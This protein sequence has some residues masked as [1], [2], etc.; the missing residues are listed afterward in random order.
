MAATITAT[1]D[2]EQRIAD[3]EASLAVALARLEIAVRR[4]RR[5][6]RENQELRLRLREAGLDWR[7]GQ[8][9]EKGKPLSSFSPKKT[10]SLAASSVSG[11]AD[12]D[13]NC[14]AA[15][16]NLP[17]TVISGDGKAPV[18]L[19]ASDDCLEFVELRARITPSE[20]VGI[21]SCS[22]KQKKRLE[23]KG[24]AGNERGW[25]WRLMGPSGKSAH[26][27]PPT[28]TKAL[29]AE[30]CDRSSKVA[31]SLP[32]SLDTNSFSSPR[33]P[34]SKM[35]SLA[36][37]S[38]NGVV[39]AAEWQHQPASLRVPEPVQEF[40]ELEQGAAGAKPGEELPPEDI[41]GA[42]TGE[43]HGSGSS[44][45]Q[46]ADSGSGAWDILWKPGGG[47]KPLRSLTFTA[48]TETR[49]QIHQQVENWADNH[50]GSQKGADELP[51]IPTQLDNPRPLLLFRRSGASVEAAESESPA[52][53]P[54]PE[55]GSSGEVVDPVHL[56]E[57]KWL[58]HVKGT[59]DIL[60]EHHIRCL[61][62]QL[63]KRMHQAPWEL[64]YSTERHGISMQTL[65][66][67]AASSSFTVLV[68]CDGAG[69]VFGSFCTEP[70]K[71]S[72]RY[73]GTGESFVFQ[74]QP[75]QIAY[76]WKRKSKERNDFF[77]FATP[78]SV[79][80]GGGGHFALWLD[81]DLAFGN[82][83]VSDTFGN[84][85]LAGSDEFRI[86]QIELWGIRV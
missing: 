33:R 1:E 74:L 72:P 80:V 45:E 62:N 18:S 43:D 3:L 51:A 49:A 56:V 73:F 21:K 17:V 44:L 26:A 81:Q 69:Y 65:F 24:S 28:S 64:L 32:K 13:G 86:K 50:S 55:A 79:A 14:K 39:S 30:D 47:G 34:G 83:G 6:R 19:L 2:A 9:D 68:I 78:D 7:E 77:Q 71:M 54:E 12:L 42:G 60:N 82:S 31:S 29:E 41:P 58:P 38:W 11:D 10:V 75:H 16:S 4:E 66:R 76:P 63:P 23:R 36:R 70:W 35:G 22:K 67:R 27:S 46:G 48:S 40:S 15:V 5:W 84:A 20:F 8:L 25:I 53:E 37:M 85:S 57:G 61:C 59:S 52:E